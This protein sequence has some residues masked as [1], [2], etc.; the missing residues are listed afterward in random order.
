MQKT[1]EIL[2]ELNEIPLVSS[3]EEVFFPE[4]ERKVKSWLPSYTVLNIH[5]NLLVFPKVKKVENGNT[6]SKA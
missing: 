3:R 5:N 6:V 4:L 2:R 1:L